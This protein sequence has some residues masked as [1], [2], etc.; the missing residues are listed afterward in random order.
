MKRPSARA[1]LVAGEPT[2]VTRWYFGGRSAPRVDSWPAWL[3]G[4]YSGVKTV[5]VH[6]DGTIEPVTSI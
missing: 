5:R 2:G 4:P 1:R 3:R 6:A